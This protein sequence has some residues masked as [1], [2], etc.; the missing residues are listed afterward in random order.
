MLLDG[1][2]VRERLAWMLFIAQSVDDR[3]S[4]VLGQGPHGLV[5]EDPAHDEIEPPFHVVCHIGDGLSDP[6]PDIVWLEINGLPAELEYADLESRAGAKRGLLKD[7]GQG[8][9]FE[10]AMGN[11]LVSQGF[12]FLSGGEQGLDFGPGEVVDGEK[13]FILHGKPLSAS[14][15]AQFPG[16]YRVLAEGIRGNNNDIRIV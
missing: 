13:V 2:Q 9:A 3:D 4:A 12:E 5:G 8:M 14:G 10:S 16:S 11:P 1:E 6:E 7:H 15:L